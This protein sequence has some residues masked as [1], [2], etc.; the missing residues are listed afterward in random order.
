MDATAEATIAW[1]CMQVSYAFAYHIDHGE[2]EELIQLWVPDGAFDRVGQVLRGHEE[3]RA[4]MRDRPNMTTRHVFT[5]FHFHR[6]EPDEAEA[7]AY[8]MSYHA[9]VPFEGEPV[10]YGTTQGRLLEFRERYVRTAEG[11]KFAEHNGHAVFRPEVW[12]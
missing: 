4:A 10:I 12:P 3:L 6:I 7:T 5:N 11:W 9:L 8:C 2:F 1:Q